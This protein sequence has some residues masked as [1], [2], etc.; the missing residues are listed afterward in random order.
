MEKLSSIENDNQIRYNKKK[1]WKGRQLVKLSFAGLILLMICYL[2]IKYAISLSQY[3]NRRNDLDRLKQISIN[4]KTR[5]NRVTQEIE[6]NTKETRTQKI[7]VTN[8]E[9]KITS[10]EADID[11]F[12]SDLEAIKKQKSLYDTKYEELVIELNRVTQENERLKGGTKESPITSINS[13]IIQTEEEKRLIEEWMGGKR[14]G[15]ICYKLEEGELLNVNII[16]DKCKDEMPTIILIKSIEEVV[17]GGYTTVPWNE[18]GIKTDKYAFIFSLTNRI[19][20][21]V[22]DEKHAIVTGGHYIS[23]GDD[24]IIGSNFCMSKFPF[25]YGNKFHSNLSNLFNEHKELKISHLEIRI[26]E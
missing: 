18:S 16:S 13:I 23:F 21:N 7:E 24:I 19:K 1:A 17:V 6:T 14:I 26:I 9:K 15:R 11:K 22:T 5:M 4:L 3:K 2:I 10:R 20:F 12:I 8:I 25:S